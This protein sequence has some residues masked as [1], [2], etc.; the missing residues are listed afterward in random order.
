MIGNKH[1][2]IFVEEK[3]SQWLFEAVF[4]LIKNEIKKNIF[5]QAF[6]TRVCRS[7][8]KLLLNIKV[9]LFWRLD[10]VMN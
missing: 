2:F 6:R 7:L 9:K 3:N 8:I 5:E 1:H 10:N 4:I